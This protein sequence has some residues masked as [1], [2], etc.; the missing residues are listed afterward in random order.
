MRFWWFLSGWHGDKNQIFWLPAHGPSREGAK[1]APEAF[2]LH[3]NVEPPPA[4]AISGCPDP[5]KPPSP[6]SCRTSE[7][8]PQR[9]G[10]RLRPHQL[11]LFA[12]QNQ[13]LSSSQCCGPVAVQKPIL[14]GAKAWLGLRRPEFQR[15]RSLEAAHL[16]CLRDVP[17]GGKD[18]PLEMSCSPQ[19][20]AGTQLNSSDYKPA[21]GTATVNPTL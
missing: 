15:W 12:L 16:A 14:R 8:R 6:P 19:T 7:P 3:F 2:E 17:L 13:Q 9:G 5:S 11:L 18:C 4:Y 10:S 21:S 20:V 1:N